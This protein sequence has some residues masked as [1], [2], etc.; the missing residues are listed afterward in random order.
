MARTLERMVDMEDWQTTGS[1]R[2]G[3]RGFGLNVGIPPGVG[4]SG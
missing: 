3:L 2:V 4:V 1:S